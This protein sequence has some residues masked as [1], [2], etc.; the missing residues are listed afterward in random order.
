M[1]DLRAIIIDDDRIRRDKV[2]SILPDYFAS[3]G[4]GFGEG[5][6]DYLKRDAEGILPDVVIMYGDDP[7]NYG[8]YIYDWMINKSNDPG[9][10]GIPVVILTGDEFSDRSIEYLELG[11]VHF[12]EGEIEES[13]LFSVI[14]EAIEEAEFRPEP[15]EPVYEE[16]RN[17]D[18]LMGQS[19]K[20]PGDSDPR[21]VVFNTDEQLANLEAALE[22][23]RK[24]AN[25]I[26]KAL[27]EA[28]A[29]KSSGRS[30]AKNK[31]NT[32]GKNRTDNI[33]KIKRPGTDEKRDGAAVK[34]NPNRNPN[35]VGD[36]AR[37][38][39]S[40]PYGAFNAQGTLQYNVPSRQQAVMPDVNR[41]AFGTQNFSNNGVGRRT[42]VIA[43]SDLKTRK[44]CS[45]FLAQKY[46]VIAVD[47]GIRTVDFFVKNRADLL[48]INPVLGQMNGIDTVRSVRMQPGG[49]MLPVMFLVGAEYTESRA[50]LMG[51][52]IVGI[53]N[54]PIQRNTLAQAVDGFFDM[55]RF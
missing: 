2:I 49:T 9:I 37:K 32:A 48:I 12:Y 41:N 7:K 8:L 51:P 33:P 21:A 4:L 26:K 55:L 45:L 1:A 53:L 42:I 20:A 34:P 27:D 29:A 6:L 16:V 30:G 44:L 50:A 52:Q 23:G 19:V 38:A 25:D 31:D 35:P 22:R 3:V 24:R 15:A 40:N 43:D 5:A 39:M 54:K 14:N 46:N 13:A 17:I 11:D 10:A 18:R 36:L 47:S 28:G